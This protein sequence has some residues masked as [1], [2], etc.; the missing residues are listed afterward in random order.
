MIIFDNLEDALEEAEWCAKD[1]R[2]KYIVRPKYNSF[3]VFPKRRKGKVKSNYIEVGF[4]GPGQFDPPR[5]EWKLGEDRPEDWPEP[6]YY[7]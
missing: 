1:E 3:E 5:S 2:R 4:G 6:E 7:K